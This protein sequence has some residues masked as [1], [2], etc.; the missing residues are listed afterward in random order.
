MMRRQNLAG[1]VSTLLLALGV[2]VGLAGTVAAGSNFDGVYTVDVTTD[3]GTCAKTS[4]GTVT[5]QD[6]HVVATSLGNATAY[7]LVA[8]DGA[9]SLQFHAGEELAHV[10]GYAKARK[11]KGTWSAPVSQCGGRWQAERQG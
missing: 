6:G 9:I 4:R 8:T 5:I 10:A 7:G 11:A 1:G 3:V 2:A